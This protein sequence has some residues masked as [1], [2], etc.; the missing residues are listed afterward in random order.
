MFFRYSLRALVALGL[1]TAATTS[2][3]ADA[4]R[5]NIVVIVGDD[6]G[7]HDL[8]VHGCKD[9]PTPHLDAL[10]TSGVRCTSGY[11]S[12]PYCSPTR[13]GL[14]TGRYQQR[15]GHEFNPGPTPTGEI[16]L[17]LSETTLADRLKKVGYKTGMVGKWH[18][19]NDEKRHPLSRGFD[20]FFGF[21][22]GA[23]TYFAT[24]GNASAGTKLLRGR[25]VVDEKEYLTDAFAREAVAYIDRS[26]ASP[27]FL[28][29]TFNAVH[30]PMEA[31]QKYLDR[32]TAV[33][34]PKRQK[35]CAMMSAM[36]DAVGQV[37]A[38][39]EREKLLE[40]TL[41]FFVSDNGGPTAANTGDNTP[42]RGFKATTWEGGIRVPYFVSWKGKIPAGK[43]YD[44]PV[45]QIDFVPTALAAAG[46]PAAEKTDGV[47][48]LPYL[49]F[50]NKEAPHAS[51]FWRFGPQTAI[52]H[53]NYKLVMTRDLDKPA[54]YDLAADI[55]ETK[56]LSAD[57]PEIVAQLT[58]AYDAWNQENI[59]AAWGA[60]SR[61]IGN[62]TPGKKAGG[63]KKNK[64]KV[65]AATPAS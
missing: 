64:A 25:E 54:L 30:T 50:E 59:P 39:L 52:R 57:K 3:A 13:A 29:L 48:L 22:G 47:N 33:S 58:A 49:T 21:L 17:P 1:L 26:K 42:L 46:A 11:V 28:Y 62:G 31:S 56:D 15:F 65:E 14:L 10:A 24:P 43:T 34:D 40:N 2:M 9:I 23:R 27:F 4:S 32:F 53:G 45:I 6:M 60:P 5:P 12:G 51:L 36:D 38:K 18:L 63:K 20:E 19:G 44:Q 37:V 16:G 35:Y 7:Y 8:G 41:I 55:S 61:A